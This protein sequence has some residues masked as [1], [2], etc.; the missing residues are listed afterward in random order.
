MRLPRRADGI[1]CG[2]VG[3]RQRVGRLPCGAPAEDPSYHGN[4][5][6]ALR[7]GPW[8][9]DGAHRA[10]SALL[11]GALP[12]S[13]AAPVRAEQGDRTLAGGG[14]LAY[15]VGG[16]FAPP[17]RDRGFRHHL[18]LAAAVGSGYRESCGTGNSIVGCFDPITGWLFGAS[19]LLGFGAYPS[20]VLADVGYGDNRGM[21]AFG[22]FLELGARVAPSRAP[23]VGVRTNVDVLLLNVGARVFTTLEHAPDLGLWLTVGIGRF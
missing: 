4:E 14:H 21:V 5:M 9:V 3:W 10:A 11:L 15:G 13:A 8:S 22:G 6:Q 17:E 23:A 16:A 20:Y 19:S 18:D 12:F 1:H 2:G 7:F